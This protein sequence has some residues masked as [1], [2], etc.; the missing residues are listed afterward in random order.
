LI[1]DNDSIRFDNSRNK[2]YLIVIKSLS[3]H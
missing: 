2:E 3:Q 1:D